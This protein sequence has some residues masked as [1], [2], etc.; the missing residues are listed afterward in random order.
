[1]D[2]INPTFFDKLLERTPCRGRRFGANWQLIIPHAS[3][4]AQ[5]AT[6]RGVR[7]SSL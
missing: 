2:A 5:V 4:G 7:R 1:M 6:D 3:G